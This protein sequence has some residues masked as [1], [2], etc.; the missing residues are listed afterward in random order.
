MV[1]LQNAGE[2]I[3]HF[4]KKKKEWQPVSFQL[5]AVEDGSVINHWFEEAHFHTNAMATTKSLTNLLSDSTSHAAKN[6]L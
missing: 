6:Y 1:V 4:M 2:S 3:H 5:S